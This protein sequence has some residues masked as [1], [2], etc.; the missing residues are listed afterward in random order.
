MTLLGSPYL[1]RYGYF[2][3]PAQKV[4]SDGDYSDVSLEGTYFDH[5]VRGCGVALL[6]ALLCKPEGRGSD[7]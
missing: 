7:R 6:V 3:F 1:E 4:S 2:A 5:L